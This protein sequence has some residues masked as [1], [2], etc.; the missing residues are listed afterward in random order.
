M[1]TFIRHG[2]PVKTELHHSTWDIELSE[3]ERA[4]KLGFKKE[5]YEFIFCSKLRRSKETALA[6]FPNTHVNEFW[7]LN[8]I[9]KD[10]ESD[11]EFEWRVATA[12]S[13]LLLPAAVKGNVFVASH[14]RFMTV[15]NTLLKGRPKAGF[16]YLEQVSYTV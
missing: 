5:D 11:V 8:E 9:D 2:L 12:L 16:D 15:A 4:A 6:I 14:N 13:K 1:I 7:I 3:K 10:P